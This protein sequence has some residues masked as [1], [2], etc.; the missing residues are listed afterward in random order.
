MET[1][2]P[3]I[4]IFPINIVEGSTS[5]GQKTIWPTDIG[6]KHKVQKETF[7]AINCWTTDTVAAMKTI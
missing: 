5:F 2:I 7:E 1:P 3:R 4:R 6:L